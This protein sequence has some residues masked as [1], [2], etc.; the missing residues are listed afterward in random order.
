MIDAFSVEVLPQHPPRTD[1]QLL[2]GV[3]KSTVGMDERMLEV[4]NYLMPC[5]PFGVCGLAA[6]RAILAFEF[7]T[8][9]LTLDH[10]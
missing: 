10:P 6:L 2:D 5:D 9:I 1:E 8:A 7:A 3:D 4:M